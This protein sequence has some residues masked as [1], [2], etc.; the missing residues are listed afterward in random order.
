MVKY[1]TQAVRRNLGILATVFL[2]AFSAQNISAQCQTCWSASNAGAITPSCSNQTLAFI[3]TT[4]QYWNATPGASYTFSVAGGTNWTT[5]WVEVY[6][7]NGSIW[8]CA[9]AGSSSVTVNPMPAA[10]T[11][12]NY[13]VVVNNGH[14]CYGAWP[15]T[16][17]AY[18]AT[19]TYVQN[20]NLS[21]TP[22]ST[23]LCSNGGSTSVTVSPTGGTL[24][25]NTAVGSVSST[26][27]TAPST[28][29]AS[30]T[31]LHYVMG[32]CAA[33]SGT[34][35]IDAQSNAGTLS[36][37]G[38]INF[39]DP[40][41]NFTTAIS[42]SGYTGTPTWYYGWSSCATATTNL[43]GCSGAWVAGAS[44]GIANFPS[45]TASSDGNA[46]RIQ[47]SVKN[48]VCPAAL[49]SVVLLQ[50]RYNAAPTSLVASSPS[51]CTNTAPGTVTLQANYGGSIDI[52]GATAFS[53]VS[54]G[55]TDLGTVTAGNSVTSV[56][57]AAFAAPTTAGVYTYYAQYQPGA[58]T[59]GYTACSNS[60]CATTTITVNSL[61]AISSV[62]AGTNPLCGGS[63]TVLTANGITGTGATVNWYTA[64]GGGGQLLGSGTTLT[65]GGDQTYYA[66][67][68]GTC[69]TPAEANLPVTL[70]TSTPS[71][72]APANITTY[73]SPNNSCAAAQVFA[74]PASSDNC[75]G[76]NAA[77][78][79]IFENSVLSPLITNLKLWVK[80]DAGVVMDGSGKVSEWRDLSGNGNHFKQATFSARPTKSAASTNFNGQNCITFTNAQF[81]TD[82]NN[83]DGAAS[84]T[85]TIFT[86]SRMTGASNFRLISSAS[87]NWLMGYHGGY[88]DK[89]YCE[90][91]MSSSGV[92]A[93]PTTVPHMYT[94]S[95][96]G[97]SPA[98]TSMWDYGVAVAL[99]TPTAAGTSGNPRNGPGILQLNGNG[100]S[101]SES[102]SGEVAE[103]IYFNTTL[104]T[105]QRQ[106]VEGYLAYKY[107]MQAP[108][109][110]MQAYQTYAAGNTTVTFVASDQS[111]NLSAPVNTTTTTATA[112]A[113]AYPGPAVAA[114]ATPVCQ[115]TNVTLSTSGMAPA[116][117]SLTTPAVNDYM[118][119]GTSST[120]S[121]V[122]IGSSWTLET[123][124]NMANLSTL[125][126]YGSWNTFFR[127][128]SVG[129]HIIV[130]RNSVSSLVLG[131]YNGGFYSSGFNLTSLSSGWHHMAAVGTGG[132]TTFY[133]DGVKVGTSAG[134]TT[135]PIVA[136]GNYQGGGQAAGQMDEVRIWNTALSQNTIS[137]NMTQAVS[138]SSANLVAYYKMDG[139]GTN[140]STSAA[141]CST[142]GGTVQGTAVTSTA[143]AFY[144]YTWS[145]PG[146]PAFS[147]SAA[148]TSE[149][150]TISAPTNANSGNYTC[151]AS[152]N[153]CSSQ[154][155]TKNVQVD[156]QPVLT[157]P[158]AVCTNGT[159]AL[160]SSVSV[161]WSVSSGT[162]NN[163]SGTAT[164]F[165]P[166][167]FAAPTQ[168]QTITIT[169]V[170][171]TCST[172]TP[173]IRVDNANSITAPTANP[174][175]VCDNSTLAITGN[176]AG[177]VWTQS[178][179]I[180]T[181]ATT[182]GQSITFTPTALTGTTQ[183][184]TTTITATNGVC[185]AQ[186]LNVR[187]DHH[188]AIT[189]PTANPSPVCDN[190][191]LAITGTVAGVVWTMSPSIGSIATTPG[192]SV[193][194]TPTALTGTTQ[195]ATTTITATN[196]VCTA[197][198]LNV[199]VDHNLAS[200][201]APAAICTNGTAAITSGVAG[202]S[203]TTT[204]GSLLPTSGQ[205]TTLTPAAIG[206]PTQNQTVTVTATNGS[207]AVPAVI[208]V[209]NL[210][211]ILTPPTTVCNSTTA[212]FSGNI[213]GVIWS[214]TA[215]TM[216]GAAQNATF[217]PQTI[218]A[219]TAN[220]NVT[221]T[222]TN[223]VCTAPTA[224]IRVD[225]QN[226]ITSPPS[227]ICDGSGTVALTGTISGVVWSTAMSAGI[228]GTSITSPGIN[229]TL[230][231]GSVTGSNA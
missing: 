189:A 70:E 27:Y 171:G 59:A 125:P 229:S 175:P 16:G 158:T 142:C 113:T 230:T 188:N 76:E 141:A 126:G 140:S 185:T 56:T 28:S 100:G 66:R 99:P 102:S 212:A 13:L 134:Q 107:N 180:G 34:I 95:S 131:T 150:V 222:A 181:I 2:I 152:A 30:S 165:T 33:N 172:N 23:E 69:A 149:S 115:G 11:A 43:T 110:S 156:A 178:P 119:V 137:N 139:N 21:A 225:N 29:T 133:I 151:I 196:G 97:I 195:N 106:L 160:S 146:S 81:L 88:Q 190:G 116:G 79:N 63:T 135:E 215:G 218:T 37:A 161:N 52:L 219:P 22:A 145:G 91:W 101:T 182:P 111:G 6:Y 74:T 68:T 210:N 164:T 85:Y 206:A 36:N 208:R 144:T 1:F 86:V 98:T 10:N 143:T 221:I 167:T 214:S 147:P 80:G 73:T 17:S 53:K 122:V 55:G 82:V 61:P 197:Q 64:S 184:A 209:D 173:T 96:P 3:P 211:S 136:I 216:S 200:V 117:K 105:A 24:S 191:T 174:S 32:A 25:N 83:I 9:G 18:S 114:S 204:A 26:T 193:T 163:A 169:A 60:T 65:V 93:V 202:V 183:N 199:R 84:S 203:W 132:T 46:D 41:G 138:P 48:G 176:I 7:Y 129:H 90:G 153:G 67:V 227:F 47:V 120:T 57:S 51:Y 103:V 155:T 121:N 186:T 228:T 231:P 14:A 207:C 201:S 166:A 8:A 87:A 226:A 94:V 154:T 157:V 224:V 162:V 78:V 128:T 118:L 104:T 89:L 72:T 20:N 177:V 45:K 35:T 217:T 31:T 44:S 40:S 220:Q 62:T 49:S 109:A 194:F 168:N 170:N 15:G 75:T 4:Y 42:T 159:A 124:F 77:T 50:D 187:V 58:N 205:N 19:L 39:C 12:G 213:S 148:S 92:L 198:T 108:L 179:S 192:Q 54:C 112:T 127:G 5:P 123:W 223:G 71:V 38:P 130:Q